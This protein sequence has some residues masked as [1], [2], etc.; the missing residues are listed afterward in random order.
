MYGIICGMK[1]GVAVCALA[2]ALMRGAADVLPAL[3]ES[4]YANTE[5]ATL[6][7][8][9]T[10]DGVAMAISV[11]IFH[12]AGMKK[13]HTVKRLNVVHSPSISRKTWQSFLMGDLV[14]VNSHIR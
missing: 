10:W 13:A 7:G 2:C 1:V 6:G 12:L 5:V 11:G 8:V 4:A 9:A 3:P 14:S